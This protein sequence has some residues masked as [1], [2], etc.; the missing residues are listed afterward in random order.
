MWTPNDDVKNKISVSTTDGLTVRNETAAEDNYMIQYFVGENV[1]LLKGTEYSIKI[2]M[3]GTTAGYATVA[4]G[5]WVIWEL[6]EELILQTSMLLI[7][8]LI[9]VLM[10]EMDSFLCRVVNLKVLSA[11]NL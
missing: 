2:T 7:H 10:K 6:L 1:P 4:M 5:S 11:L 9:Q 8:C 3:K